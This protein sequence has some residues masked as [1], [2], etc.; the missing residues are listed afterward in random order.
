MYSFAKIVGPDLTAPTGSFRSGTIMFASP[1][2][3]DFLFSY[4]Q[5]CDAGS[6]LPLKNGFDFFHLYLFAMQFT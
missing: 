1:C 3:K 2:Y 4:K 6:K 5:E